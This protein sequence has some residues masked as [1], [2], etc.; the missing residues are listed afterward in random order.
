M[1]KKA[2]RSI[3]A[4]FPRGTI[5]GMEAFR[6]KHIQD[7][8][9]EVP[10]HVTV[11]YDFLL[12][13]QINGEAVE[14]LSAIASET[15]CFSF[16]ARPISSFPTTRVLYLSP[17]PLTP[18]ESLR[19]KLLKSFSPGGGVQEIA[20]VFHMTLALGYSP[21]EEEEIIQ[22]YFSRF[23]KNPLYLWAGSLGIYIF[24]E[25]RWE[26]YLDFELGGKV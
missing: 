20:P 8:G 5:N 14:K 17:T 18:I 7:V 23:G 15:P 19:A 1:Q 21:G 13:E 3:V 26:K 25:G 9:R 4:L 6:K 11:L 22:E 2:L 24:T 12:P 16:W 10:F